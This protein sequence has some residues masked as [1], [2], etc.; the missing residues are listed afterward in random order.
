MVTLREEPSMFCKGWI[1]TTGLGAYELF[2]FFDNLLTPTF[3][4]DPQPITAFKLKLFSRS[5]QPASVDRIW[6]PG[7]RVRE[8]R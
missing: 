8:S 4:S 3:K 2:P 5:K 1:Y 7:K 6:L